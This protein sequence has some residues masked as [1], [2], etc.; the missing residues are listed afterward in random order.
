MAAG[1]MEVGGVVV[2]RTGRTYNS[3]GLPLGPLGLYFEQF[4]H[5]G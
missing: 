3:Q 2:W 5:Q 1:D 4:L